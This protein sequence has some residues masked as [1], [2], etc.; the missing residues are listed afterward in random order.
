MKDFNRLIRECE[1]ELDALAF[2]YGDIEWS[3]N[4]RAKKRWGQCK[5]IGSH[6][7]SISI[8]RILLED[9]VDD[10]ATKTTMIH[11]ML[12]AVDK[13]KNGHK[14]NWLRLANTVRNAYGYDIKRTSTTAE[15]GIVQPAEEPNYKYIY[16][17]LGCGSVVRKIRRSNFT[18]HP[19]RYICPECKGKFI[20]K[21]EYD[22]LSEKQRVELNKKLKLVAPYE[23]PR[24]MWE[25]ILKMS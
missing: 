1:S 3:I 4:T 15:K 24:K 7:Y 23:L 2:D 8:A 25:D 22:K 11:E 10:I 12:H 17:C 20:E 21:R 13:N 5:T 19:N 14:G 6:K 9:D 18:E 16:V